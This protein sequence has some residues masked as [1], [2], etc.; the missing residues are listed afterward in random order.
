MHYVSQLSS[1]LVPVATCYMLF[2]ALALRLVMDV[3]IRPVTS[4]TWDDLELL[5]ER[6]GGPRHCYCMVNREM[7]PRYSRADS[8]AKKAALREYV[9]R[10]VPVGMLAYVDGAAVGWCSVAPLSSH[11]R[12]RTR[13]C[14]IEDAPEDVVW[15]I[16][17]F[18]IR[19]GARR[20]GLS[21]RLISAA[22]E[23]AAANGATVIEAYPVAPDSPSWRYMGYVQTFER[24][25]FQ[26]VG[27][28][29]KRR[30]VMQLLV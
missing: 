9:E 1:G 5:F 25:G 28:S 21:T 19:T 20:S 16:S 12:L 14:E 15:S 11:V 22:I 10:G 23:Y 17:C 2:V 29:G 13:D 8:P 7:E 4:D 26:Q 18:Y 3:E 24:L 27:M 6:R 30:H